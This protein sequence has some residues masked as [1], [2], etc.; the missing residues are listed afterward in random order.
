MR[1]FA[2]GLFIKIEN[3]GK[4]MQQISA[5]MWN[6]TI[7]DV[8]SYQRRATEFD[9]VTGKQRGADKGRR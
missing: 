4:Q 6:R 2:S 8:I 9:P 1:F 5:F 3:I 7:A